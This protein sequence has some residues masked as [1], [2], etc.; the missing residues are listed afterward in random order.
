MDLQAAVPAMQAAKRRPQGR[1]NVEPAVGP[2]KWTG[3]FEDAAAAF[4][5]APYR[6][7]ERMKTQ[8]HYGLTME[9]RG[10]LAEW[11]AAQGRLTVWGAAKVLFANRRILARLPRRNRNPELPPILT[12]SYPWSSRR[13]QLA[14]QRTF[15]PTSTCHPNIPSKSVATTN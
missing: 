2:R 15:G 9:P 5:D 6:R 11:D 14:S 10:V 13:S 4:K 3:T 1:R 12:S 8:R 7:R